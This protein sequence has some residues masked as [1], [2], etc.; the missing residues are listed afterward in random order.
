MIQLPRL[1]VIILMWNAAQKSSTRICL[2]CFQN[3]GLD[4]PRE[5]HEFQYLVLKELWYL[6]FTLK[7][8]ISTRS[9]CLKADTHLKNQSLAYHANAMVLNT[10]RHYKGHGQPHLENL[11]LTIHSPSEQVQAAILLIIVIQPTAF[12]PTI[13]S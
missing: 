8:Y 6:L 11:M 4:H 5:G 10:V 13:F 9:Y 3:S 1:Y 2:L 12:F 7:G